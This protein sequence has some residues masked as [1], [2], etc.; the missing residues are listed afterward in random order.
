MQWGGVKNEHYETPVVTVI[1]MTPE[2]CFT[3]TESIRQ[4]DEQGWY[5]VTI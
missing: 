3:W 2:T 1:E 5:G 4:D